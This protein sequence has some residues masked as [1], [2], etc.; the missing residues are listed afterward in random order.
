MLGRNCVKKRAKKRNR[1]TQVNKRV[2]ETKLN[3][4]ILT[5]LVGV[6]VPL[7]DLPPVLLALLFPST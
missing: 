4:R 1:D 3:K 7:A 5:V 2:P 6:E